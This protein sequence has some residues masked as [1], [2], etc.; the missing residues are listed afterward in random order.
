MRSLRCETAGPEQQSTTVTRSPTDEKKIN[1]LPYF[2]RRKPHTSKSKV[3]E[4]RRK[5]EF[6]DLGGSIPQDT[7]CHPVK[8]NLK[9]IKIGTL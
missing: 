5:A 7:A 8:S 9:K 3:D 6:W 2:P 4:A 1:S